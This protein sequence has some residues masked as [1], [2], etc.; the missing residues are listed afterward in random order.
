MIRLEKLSKTFRGR[1]ALIDLSLIIEYCLDHKELRGPAIL[2]EAESTR[3]A[4]HICD[5]V[6]VKRHPSVCSPSDVNWLVKRLAAAGY[7]LRDP[8]DV[9]GLTKQREAQQS[10]V[11]S[12]AVYLGKPS[13]P[14]VPEPT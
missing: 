14:F 10:A 5:V 4:E 1:P 3:L 11:E 13:A 2:L 9:G 7:T 12:I 8:V 6:H